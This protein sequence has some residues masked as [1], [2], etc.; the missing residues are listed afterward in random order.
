MERAQYR[1][2]EAPL[3]THDPAWKGGLGSHEIDL[4]RRSVLQALMWAV[5]VIELEIVI[6]TSLEFP[7]R[8]ILFQVE[9]F[10]LHTA[11][12][13]LNEDVVEGPPVSVHADVDA[14]GFQ[15]AGEIRCRKLHALIRIEDRWRTPSQ[16][17]LQCLYTEGPVERVGELPS[18]HETTEPV[19]NRDQIHETVPHGYV[20]DVR[21]PDQIGSSDFQIAQQIGID[22]VIPGGNRCLGPGVDRLQAHEPH[23]ATDAL[24]IDLIALALQMHRH[25][26]SVSVEAEQRYRCSLPTSQ[27]ARS[28]AIHAHQSLYHKLEHALDASQS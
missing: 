6:Q 9:I 4:S 12:E 5:V 24:A 3:S 18:Q 1:L 8:G 28:K 22:P 21:R 15:A 20:G 19:K 10:V 13:A 7:H 25:A 23:Q 11:P 2:R 17:L 26:D 27:V 16:R 14:S